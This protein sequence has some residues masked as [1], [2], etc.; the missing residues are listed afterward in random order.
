MLILQKSKI[1]HKS[2]QLV[3]DGKSVLHI[4]EFMMIYNIIETTGIYIGTIKR[5]GYPIPNQSRRSNIARDFKASVINEGAKP[6][7]EL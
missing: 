6:L 2:D 4:T 5:C 1:I 3:H 7:S